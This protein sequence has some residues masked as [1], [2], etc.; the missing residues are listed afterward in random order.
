M[1]R[2]CA[3]IWPEEVEVGPPKGLELDKGE[4]SRVVEG[5]KSL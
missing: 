5:L 2:G 1:E 3:V 4:G